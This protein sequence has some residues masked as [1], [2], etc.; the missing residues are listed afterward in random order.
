MQH[1]QSLLEQIGLNHHESTVYL[2][3]LESGEK[4][5][6]VVARSVKIPRSTVRNV[7]DK[8][9]ERGIVQKLYKRNTQHYS[10]K[11]PASLTDYLRHTMES[12]K[13][14]IEDITK[15][16]PVLSALH[17]KRAVV[18]KV[19]VFEGPRQVIE[20]FNRSLYEEGVQEL[21]IFT[22]YEF[23]KN[24][25]IRKN[26]DDFFIK[27]RVKK[28][29]RARVLVGRT[30]QSIKMTGNDPK[31]LRKRRFSP[32]K[33]QLPGNLH[34]YGNS[35]MY[36]SASKSEYLAILTESK[37]MADTMRTLFEFMWEQCG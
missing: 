21:L 3:L 7:L 16:M 27:M 26:D 8:L 35:V 29:I 32:Q 25:L 23:L 12:A 9:C 18:P 33:Y 13:Q 31:E 22:S 34:V 14:S 2:H 10:C 17:G 11:P 28:G 1:L 24:P 4:P 30:D 5:A 37:M 19:R 36:F 20:A 6:S 15:A